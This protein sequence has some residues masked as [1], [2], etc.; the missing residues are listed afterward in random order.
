MDD[1]RGEA[2][3]RAVRQDVAE[4]LVRY[5]SGIDG[6]D[7]AQLRSCFTDDCRADYGVIGQWA[8]G[9]D[10]TDWM[11]ETHEPLGPTLHRITNIAVRVD[12][13]GVT[14]RSYVDA[15]V[16]M[17]D[18][19]S[20]TRATGFYDDVLVR[21]ADGW[22]ISQ[23]RFTTVLLQLEPDGTIIDLGGAVEAAFDAP[24]DAPAD[25]PADEPADETGGG[26]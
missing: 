19:Q 5:A 6:R 20:G 15:L 12:G 26:R 3:A 18:G 11:R 25:G 16:L 13:D 1:D 17:P 2:E 22:Q 23:R 7:W 24:A 9:D 8:R 10:I 4:V 14:A 21:T